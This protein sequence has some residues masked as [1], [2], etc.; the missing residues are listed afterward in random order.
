MTTAF[1]SPEMLVWARE[2]QH[3]KEEAL[4]SS[5]HLKAG[6]VRD[7]ERGAAMPTL[8]QAEKLAELLKVPLPFLYL[9]SPP[10]VE[11]PLPD[12]RTIALREH[13]APSSDFVD[14]AN[15][16]KRKQD[17]YRD[18]RKSQSLPELGFVAS[19]RVEDSPLTVAAK[20]R[21]GLRLPADQYRAAKSWT[22]HLGRLTRAAEM[23]GVLVFR[24]GIVGNNTRRTLDVGEF[25]R[26]GFF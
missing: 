23:T 19:C 18:Y 6:K 16:V 15:A 2:R 10:S 1:I 5:L 9:K 4:A 20:L 22:D 11:L 13:P 24:S 12:R 14:T 26:H 21:E 3:V 25:R 7:W 17:W 8:R